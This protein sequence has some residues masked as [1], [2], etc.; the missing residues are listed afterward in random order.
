MA[1]DLRRLVEAQFFKAWNE[2]IV[3]IRA[4]ADAIGDAI[5]ADA[6]HA[7]AVFERAADL[8]RKHEAYR[9]AADDVRAMNSRLPF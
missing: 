2:Y 7:D 5:E 3:A 9:Q 4:H 8:E 1:T 6:V